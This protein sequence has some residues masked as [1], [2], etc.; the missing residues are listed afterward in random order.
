M[1]TTEEQRKWEIQRVG[2]CGKV[3]IKVIRDN[4]DATHNNYKIITLSVSTLWYNC[5]SNLTLGSCAHSKWRKKQI[6]VC[7]LCSQGWSNSGIGIKRDHCWL[8]SKTKAKTKNSCAWSWI[9]RSVCEWTWRLLENG[10]MKRMDSDV[11][12]GG[13]H[14]SFLFKSLPGVCV[15]LWAL[16]N[17]TLIIFF[18]HV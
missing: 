4:D 10:L 11:T 17:M 15:S 6:P 9:V 5:S 18:F 13:Q 2:F 1:L 14:V 8:K 12:Q 7:I 16:V 3:L